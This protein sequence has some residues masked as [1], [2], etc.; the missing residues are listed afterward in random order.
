MMR[1]MRREGTEIHREDTGYMS[2]DC[3]RKVKTGWEREVEQG[4]SDVQVR[5]EV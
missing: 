2:I 4:R 3:G 1:E 5:A